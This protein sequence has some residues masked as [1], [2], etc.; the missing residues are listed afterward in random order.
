MCMLYVFLLEG[1]ASR[2]ASVIGEFFV[3]PM[4]LYGKM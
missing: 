2:V 1:L 3:A 4:E